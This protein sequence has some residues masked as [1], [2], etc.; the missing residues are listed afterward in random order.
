MAMLISSIMPG[1]PALRVPRRRGTA[2]RRTRRS[3]CPA[4]AGPS[5]PREVQAV[6]EPLHDHRAGD[7]HR[8]GEHQAPPEPVQHLALCPACWSC[9]PLVPAPVSVAGRVPVPGTVVVPVFMGAGSGRA[10]PSAEGVAPSAGGEASPGGA[11]CGPD[12]VHGRR[13]PPGI[14]ECEPSHP[15]PR[16][17]RRRPVRCGRPHRRRVLVRLGG[18]A[19]ARSPVRSRRPRA[20]PGAYP[21]CRRASPAAGAGEERGVPDRR[22][23]AHP[24]RR[25]SGSSSRAHPHRESQRRADPDRGA[26]ECHWHPA[27]EHHQQ[28]PPPPA[29]TCS[30][31]P[32][33]PVQDVAPQIRPSVIA[34][35]K[36]AKPTAPN[37]F[38]TA[39][40]STRPTASQSLATPSLR[41]EASTHRS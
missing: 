6:P 19:P 8:D 26:E 2:P 7:D 10:E 1:W 32:P 18:P 16:V 15:Q 13:Y 9:P 29:L 5:R 31:H 4:P 11:S 40:P 37:A 38:D 3:P 39:N 24:D 22:D 33:P 35:T 12:A 30:A 34:A 14:M 25:G 27:T 36:I 20:T 28:N 17:P 23:H 21:R 41:A